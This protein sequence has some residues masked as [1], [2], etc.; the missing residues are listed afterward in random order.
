MSETV[1]RSYCY[2]IFFSGNSASQLKMRNEKKKLFLRL[3]N[4]KRPNV[5]YNSDCLSNYCLQFFVHNLF[6]KSFPKWPEAMA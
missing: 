4:V 2:K 6:R 5:K 3:D 1:I